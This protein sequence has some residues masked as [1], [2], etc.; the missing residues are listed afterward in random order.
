MNYKDVMVLEGDYTNITPEYF[1]GTKSTEG[2]ALRST[3]KNLFNLNE[4][5]KLTDDIDILQVSKDSLT[6]T[7]G[8]G[9]THR[10]QLKANTNYVYSANVN[11]SQGASTVRIRVDKYT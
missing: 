10:I 2:I 1:V 3:G 4:Y 6:T 7:N 9:S 11:N 8:V 5:V